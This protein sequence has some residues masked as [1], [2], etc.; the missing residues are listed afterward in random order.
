MPKVLGL[1]QYLKIVPCGLN[2][3]KVTSVYK[4]IEIKPKNYE[5]KLAEIFIKNIN[6]L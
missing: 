2:N 6:K 3:K 4:E 1:D 5:K